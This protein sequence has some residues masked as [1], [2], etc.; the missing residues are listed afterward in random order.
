LPKGAK[1]V[2]STACGVTSPC[3]SAAPVSKANKAKESAR[4]ALGRKEAE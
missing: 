2:V 4:G 3:A 1:P